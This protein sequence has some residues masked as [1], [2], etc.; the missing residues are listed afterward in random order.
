VRS[1]GGLL[2]GAIGLAV[3]DGVVSRQQA[4]TNVGGWIAS[5][6]SLVNRFLDPTIPLFSTTTSSS[7]ATTSSA[8]SSGSTSGTST[9]T[10][11]PT[12]ILVAAAAPVPITI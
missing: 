12:D 10:A 11:K 1:W 6:G 3:L 8:T 9:A 7:S 4:A 2:I 5:A